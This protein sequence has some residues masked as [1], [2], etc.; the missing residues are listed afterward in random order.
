MR[1]KQHCKNHIRLSYQESNNGL[2]VSIPDKIRF[3]AT[4]AHCH[5]R[6]QHTLVMSPDKT[7]AATWSYQLGVIAQSPG[8]RY[9]IIDAVKGIGAHFRMTNVRYQVEGPNLIIS[10][11]ADSDRLPPQKRG[12]RKILIETPVVAQVAKVI[13]DGEDVR[14]AMP[15]A[16]V[17]IDMHGKTIDFKVPFDQIMDLVLEWNRRGY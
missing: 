10:I 16:D 2:R 14:A 6:D 9:F 15:K 4:I 17:L 1:A 13:Q 8:S 7:E 12:R 5:L 11:P 3:P